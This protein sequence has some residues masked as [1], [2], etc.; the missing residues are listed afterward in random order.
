MNVFIYDAVTEKYKKKTRKFEEQINKLGLQGK[1]LYLNS[2]KNP[3]ESIEKE[4]NSGAKTIIILGNDRTANLVVNILANISQNIPI[5]IVPIGKDNLIAES[6]GIENEKDAAFILSARRT[7][8]IKLGKINHLF[9]ISNCQITNKD[10]SIKIDDSYSVFSQK[11]TIYK[12]VNL[13]DKDLFSKN[14]KSSPQDDRLEFFVF[15]KNKDKTILPINKVIEITNNNFSIL[16]DNSV[17]ISL[18]ATISI[19][20]KKITFVVGKDRT[21]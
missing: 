10:T 15:N 18:P 9:F 8:S 13:A 5:F 21:F 4:I 3:A 7:E 11:E 1:I 14:T 2:I 19:S 12:I 6:L 17:Q 20:D 16:L